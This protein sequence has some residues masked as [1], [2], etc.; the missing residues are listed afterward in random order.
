MTTVET[1]TESQKKK[2]VD[3]IN[4][5]LGE[6]TKALTNAREIIGALTVAGKGLDDGLVTACTGWGKHLD[7]ILHNVSEES[8]AV[9]RRMGGNGKTM[10]T[11]KVDQAL[12][13][14]VSAAREQITEAA[15]T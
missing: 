8:S 2:L 6:V 3:A 7:T 4:E 5:D 14:T 13:E 1:H 15:G 12:A 10:M 11:E 9:E